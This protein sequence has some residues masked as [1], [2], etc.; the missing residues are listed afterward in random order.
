[1][2]CP[3]HNGTLKT[4]VSSRTNKIS[5]HCFKSF[6]FENS[7]DLSIS[8]VETMEDII[9]LIHFILEN[10]CDLSI[11]AVETVEEIIILIHFILE[12]SCDLSISAVEAMEE[13]I[14]QFILENFNKFKIIHPTNV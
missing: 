14:I 10:S 8:A 12:N 6:N 3:I 11:S 9:I 4:S 7:C 13:I 2:T 5:L 1:M